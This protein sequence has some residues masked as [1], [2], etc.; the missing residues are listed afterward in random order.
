MYDKL[1]AI[2]SRCDKRRF[3]IK[4][5]EFS[6]SDTYQEYSR[7]KHKYPNLLLYPLYYKKN[8]ESL[9]K[10]IINFIEISKELM[11]Y[12]FKHQTNLKIYKVYSHSHKAYEQ[13]IEINKN[14]EKYIS[15][16]MLIDDFDIVPYFLYTY[17]CLNFP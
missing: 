3:S 6:S 5:S 1:L 9:V 12:I 11:K 16:N 15:S 2:D 17:Y 14:Y 7:Y 13:N 10:M 8:I 4:S